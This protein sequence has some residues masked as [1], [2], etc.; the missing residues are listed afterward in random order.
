MTLPQDGCPA[1]IKKKQ[2]EDF[3]SQVHHREIL[4][5]STKN[6]GSFFFLS[7]PPILN[8]LFVSLGVYICQF[9]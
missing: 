3:T 2:G 4:F 8:S 1:Q 5:V 9:V 6:M 7:I